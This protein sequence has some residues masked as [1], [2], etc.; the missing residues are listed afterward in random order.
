MAES[1][2]V[3]CNLALQRAQVAKRIQNLDTDTSAEAGACRDS[4]DQ[5]RD[6]VLARYR[7]PF[8]EGQEQLSPLGSAAWASTTNY[9]V[10]DTVSYGARIYRSLQAVNLNRQ[11]DTSETFWRRV[12]RDGWAYVFVLP[13]DCIQPREVYSGARDPRVSESTP[14]R[15]GYDR[16]LGRLLFCDLP[17]PDLRYT[18]RVDTPVLY[19]AGFTN[20]LA[21]RLS[22]DLA[23]SQKADVQ[24]AQA[25]MKIY[26]LAAEAGIAES[27]NGVEPG[28]QPE[29]KFIDGRS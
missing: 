7:W 2:A 18:A 6:E 22:V 26:E 4:Y 3:I 13:A 8:A 15:Q 28:E 24:L 9:V 17:A 29:S 23:Q 27:L 5:A 11:P 14:F 20:A 12:S 21:W 10:G 16:D 19:P 1:K 25:N